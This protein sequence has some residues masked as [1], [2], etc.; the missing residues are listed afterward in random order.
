M[1]TDDRD[2]AELPLIDREG[3]LRRVGGSEEV[4]REVYRNIAEGLPGH[5]DRCRQAFRSGD[6]ELLGRTA[7]TIK[8]SA[9]T[10]GADRTASFACRL[11]Q[12]C[13]EHPQDTALLERALEDLSRNVEELLATIGG[14]EG[15]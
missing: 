5:V 2:P 12:S 11:H 6:L 15:S 3:L 4:A 14:E 13:R 10:A 9:A 1:T 8:G 7:H